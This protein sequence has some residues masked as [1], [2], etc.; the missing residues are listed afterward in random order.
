[1]GRPEH[2]A[3]VH[4]RLDQWGGAERMLWTLHTIFPDAP[5]FTAV[6]N[7]RAVP[8]FRGC[9]IRTSW[10]Q[11]LPGIQR[12]PRLYAALYPVAFARMDLHGFDLVISLT[13]SFAKGIRTD[14]GSLHVCYCNSPSNFIWRPDDY[15]TEGPMR[16]FTSP[17]RAW[18]KAWDRY[19]ARQPDVYVTSGQPV[20]AR[21]RSF[22]HQEA[23]IVPPSLDESWFVPHQSDDFYLVVGRLVLH[24]RIDL[25]IEACAQLGV[26]LLVAGEGRAAASL[27]RRA[28]AN[29]QFLGR[30]P[31]DELRQLYARAR[32]VLVPA[33]E[34]FG[35]VPLEAQA[36]GT[37]VIAYAAGGAL[38]TVVDGVT[39]IHFFRQTAQHLA[40]AIRTA[41][42][43]K[44]D[45]EC[46]RANA[47]RFKER[48]FR[49]DLIALI[50]R[51]LGARS[52]TFAPT[53]IGSG[54]AL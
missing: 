35:L 38:E 42:A 25:A 6:W 28:P 53:P 44:W 48:R 3:L 47:G 52:R 7:R 16:L 11:R 17:L 27:R 21:I 54:N 39:G 24:K 4:D 13:T 51:H 23:A 49:G 40:A 22:Y 18:L 1:M 20:A 30:V 50:E 46:I 41:D 36:A 43:R 10:M 34:D 32:A 14:A 37:P 29:V 45:R 19:A 8:Q 15:F 31:D 5:I 2:V 26:P 12:A 9:D 33:E